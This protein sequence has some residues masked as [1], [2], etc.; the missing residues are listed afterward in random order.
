M[1]I[2]K[3]SNSYQVRLEGIDG[4]ILSKTFK[5][6]IEAREQETLWKREK[7]EGALGT[8]AERHLTLKEFFEEWFKN[9][10]EETP[11]HMRTGWRKAQ[12]QLFDDYVSPLIGAHKLRELR[13]HHVQ[14]VLIQMAK[15]GKSDQ[16][17]VHAFGLLRKMF[18]DAIEIYQYVTFNPALNKFKPKIV[19]RETTH[20]NLEQTKTLLTHVDG[21]KYGL[22][23]WIQLY[24]GLRV[25]ELQALRW[26][27]VDLEEGRI[28]IRRTFV[29]KVKAFRDYPKGRKQ[30]SHNLPPELWEKLLSA[31]PNSHWDLVVTSPKGNLIPYLWYLRA[32]KRYCTE[33]NIPKIRTHGLRHS[34]SELYISHGASRDDLRALFAHSSLKVTERYLH[35]KDTNLAK[36]SNLIQLFP[37]STDPKSTQIKSCG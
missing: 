30:H 21:K 20:L 31:R 33:L 28:T 12:K 26:E 23:I 24:M 13:P 35:G 15:L 34:T 19:V 11:E 4:R 37:V 9:V 5:T 18:N 32:L 6:K 25:G 8:Y 14:Q 29:R 10:V 3:R 27:D 17:R 7:Q 16:T 1:S 2:I 36:V 22:A